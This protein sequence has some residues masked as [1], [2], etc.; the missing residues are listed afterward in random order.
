MESHK[1]S[2][3]EAAESISPAWIQAHGHAQLFGWVGTFILGIGFYSIPTLRK[4][5]PSA[6]WEA[7]TC[8]SLWTIGVLISWLSNLSPWH[9]HL[10]LR[11]S[12]AMDRVALLLF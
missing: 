11:L 5:K 9:W 8:W 6:L 4:L 10:L 1:I 3:R 7:W 12:A 2:S